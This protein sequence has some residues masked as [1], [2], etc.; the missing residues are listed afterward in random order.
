VYLTSFQH[1]LENDN[2]L[3]YKEIV[4]TFHHFNVFNQLNLLT[5][6][7]DEQRY[8]AIIFAYRTK[9]DVSTEWV[10]RISNNRYVFYKLPGLAIAHGCHV[11]EI[12]LMNAIICGDKRTINIILQTTPSIVTNNVNKL[13]FLFALMERIVN[14]RKNL[15]RSNVG[16]TNTFIF[17]YVDIMIKHGAQATW[18]D[19]INSVVWTVPRYL[20]YLKSAFLLHRNCKDH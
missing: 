20:E 13:P 2:T 9:Q 3:K 6:F 19:A 10:Q 17:S 18:Y 16:K 14:C 15:G 7:I 4:K 1:R 12:T 5:N 8:L 11:T